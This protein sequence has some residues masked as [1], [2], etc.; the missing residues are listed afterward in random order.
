MPVTRTEIVCPYC[1]SSNVTL[2][3]LSRDMRCVQI[4]CA[5]CGQEFFAPYPLP[6]PRGQ[7]D[8]AMQVQSR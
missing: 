3:G 1:H 6:E 5:A 2:R 4:E 8:L 7:R